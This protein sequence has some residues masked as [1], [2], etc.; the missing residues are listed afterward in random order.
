[1][2]NSNTIW[3]LNR[4]ALIATSLVLIILAGGALLVSFVGIRNDARF[5]S[6]IMQM[7]GAMENGDFS[8]A[9]NLDIH[10]ENKNEYGRIAIALKM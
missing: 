10:E 9:K 7:L 1:M 6:N 3:D 8:V 4:R 2:I 5:L